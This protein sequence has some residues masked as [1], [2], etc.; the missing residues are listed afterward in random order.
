MNKTVFHV[1]RATKTGKT[2]NIGDFDT[3]AEAQAAMLAHYNATPKRGKFWYSISED[4]LKE[5]GG[6]VFR[7]T[8]LVISGN[9]PYHK[10]FTPDELK[11]LAESEAA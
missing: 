10:T 1:S 6:V 11:K 4:T 9:G 2:V 8:C 7:E 5:I 3:Q